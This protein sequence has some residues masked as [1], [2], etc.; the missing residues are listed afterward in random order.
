MPAMP[1][2]LSDFLPD[3]E[4]LLAGLTPEQ[5]RLPAPNVA[6]VLA[7]FAVRKP[8]FRVRGRL[9]SADRAPRAPGRAVP[10]DRGGLT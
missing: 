4:D 1:R 8:G 6:A 3:P 9:L 2:V 5:W 10:D 7:G